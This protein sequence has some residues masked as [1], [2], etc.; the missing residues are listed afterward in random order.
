MQQR[1]SVPSHGNAC[2][3][4][5]SHWKNGMSLDR[6]LTLQSARSR[7]DQEFC[8]RSASFATKPRSAFPCLWRICRQACPTTFCFSPRSCTS[9]SD[10]WYVQTQS[11][12]D[13]DNVFCS[14]HQFAV[15]WVHAARARAVISLFS[16]T[17]LQI[18]GSMYLAMETAISGSVRL[19]MRARPIGSLSCDR[20]VQT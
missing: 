14:K 16:R 9:Y 1:V 5:A 6:T 19:S 4:P 10:S 2:A 20:I 13:A 11:G 8:A 7:S 12:R 3:L 18:A 17:Q 15:C